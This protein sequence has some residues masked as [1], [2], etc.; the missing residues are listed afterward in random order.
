MNAKY[1]LK[2]V[3]GIYMIICEKK[4]LPYYKAKDMNYKKL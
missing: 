3:R 1:P 2:H 4:F